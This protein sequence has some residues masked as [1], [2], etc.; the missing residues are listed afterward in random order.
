M[1]KADGSTEHVD[2][3]GVVGRYPLLRE[4]GG[5]RDD[6]QDRRCRLNEGVPP[7]AVRPGPGNGLLSRFCAFIREIRDFN[8]EM[9]GTNRESVTM[10]TELPGGPAVEFVYQSMAGRGAVQ[11]ARSY[12]DTLLQARCGA[13]A[14]TAKASSYPAFSS[15]MMRHVQAGP[16]PLVARFDLCQAAGS[17]QPAPPSTSKW[18]PSPSTSKTTFSNANWSSMR[19]ITAL[20][21]F[22]ERKVKLSTSRGRTARHHG[23]ASLPLG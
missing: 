3:S 14:C 12:L 22:A 4:G 13:R 2:G 8:R 19:A 23:C 5:Y 16:P 17:S 10:Y 21:G 9:Y 15:S 20:R 18:P 6:V 7:E 11:L 1:G